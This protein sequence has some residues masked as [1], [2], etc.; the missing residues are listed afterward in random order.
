MADSYSAMVSDRPYRGKRSPEEA[1]SELRGLSGTQFDPQV[2]VAF[3]DI[4]EG[5]SEQYRRA[6]HID[7][8]LQFQ[9]VR[10]LGDF[11]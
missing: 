2:V 8:R 5:E 7:F 1:A 6:E 3:L 9:K 11:A 4:L 10:F